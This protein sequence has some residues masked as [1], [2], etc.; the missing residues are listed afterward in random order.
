[1]QKGHTY[2]VT[3]KVYDRRLIKRLLPFVVQYRKNFI[4]AVILL[5]G[6]SLL[7]LAGPYLTKTA[8]DG[9]IKNGDVEGLLTIAL[10]YLATLVTS[11]GLQYLQIYIMALVGQRIMYDL[12]LRLFRHLQKLSLTYFDANPVGKIMTRLTSDIETLNE[13]LSSGL[14]AMMG[15]LFTVAG[16]LGMLFYLSPALASVVSVVLGLLFVL[17]FLFK[18]KMREAFRWVRSAIAGINAYLQENI[19][20]MHV[21]QLFNRQAVNFNRFQE[22]NDEHLRANL[23]TIFYF[24]VFRPVVELMNALALTLILI[25]GG[26]LEPK[27]A[28]TIGVLVAFIE[29]AQRIFYPIS[30][31][32]D[33]YN[34]LQAAMAG[35]ERIFDILDTDSQIQDRESPVR[36]PADRCSIVFDAVS[37]AYK[38]EEWVLKNVSFTIKPGE[39][40]AIVGAT[41]SGKTTIISLL[42]RF[43]DPQQGKILLGDAELTSLAQ[44]QVRQRIGLVLQ[45]P[46]LFSGTIEDNIKLDKQEITTQQARNAFKQLGIE[47]FLDTLP[48]GLAEVVGERGGRLSAGQRQLVALA[49]IMIY[50]PEILVLDEATSNIDSET[51][52]LVQQAMEAVWKNRTAIVIAHRLS[53]IQK[54]NRVLVFHNGELREQGTHAQL[55]A[56]NGIYARLHKL[57]FSKELKAQPLSPEPCECETTADHAGEIR[58]TARIGLENRGSQERA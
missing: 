41:G 55:V 42:M 53:T 20:G 45:D 32:A 38:A 23:R 37:F 9:P 19:S 43:Y 10:I 57:Y 27:G 3:H 36:L 7:R 21:I 54:V 22:L 6:F 14:V 12:R 51:E 8:I 29:Y 2:G 50:D 35:A 56:L 49:R 40:V 39:R 11:L 47:R 46:F 33:N 58:A 15:D 5:L 26:I 25:G 18:G 28:L 30:D 44:A 16:I 52:Y 17:T 34:T 48:G 13:V 24:G 31:L 4:G 1:M